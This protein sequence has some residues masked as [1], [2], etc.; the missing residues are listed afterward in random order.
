MKQVGDGWWLWIGL[1]APEKDVE[2]L[3][4]GACEM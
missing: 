2:V 4:P 1:C 3:T